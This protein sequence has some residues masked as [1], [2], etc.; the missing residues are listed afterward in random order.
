MNRNILALALAFSAMPL[1]ALAQNS[2][3]PAPTDQQRQAIHQTMDRFAQ[4]EEQLRQ[5]MRSQI[6]AALTPVHLRAVAAT[7]GQLAIAE[8]PDPQAAAK[9]LDEML[10]SSERGRILAAHE[11]FKAQSRQLHDQMRS[12][13]QSEM[14]AGQPDWMRHGWQNGMMSQQR[15][16]DPGTVLL[17]ALSPHPTFGRG[18]GMMMPGE[19]GPPQ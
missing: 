3:P 4:Q 12:E 15:M 2:A 8:N 6:L 9:R 1:A 5:Q 7:I 10:S 13:L 18:P 17:A 16:S 14:P 11:A 19:G